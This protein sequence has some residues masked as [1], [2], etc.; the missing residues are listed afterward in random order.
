MCL[1]SETAEH[2][3][4]YY[5]MCGPQALNPQDV[6]DIFS[7]VIGKSVKWNELKKETFKALPPPICQAYTNF[8]DN[9]CVISDSDVP[10][11]I[12]QAGTFEQFV[13]DHLHFFETTDK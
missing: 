9:K 2:D 13:R 6:A 10:K 12:G 1:T 4:K 11:L 8:V 3:A 7:R 5:L